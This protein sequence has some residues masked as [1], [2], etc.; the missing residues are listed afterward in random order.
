MSASAPE[1]SPRSSKL[2][3]SAAGWV[4][5]F[6]DFLDY[7][8]PLHF[9]LEQPLRPDDPIAL[10][11]TLPDPP[12]GDQSDEAFF[13]LLRDGSVVGYFNRCAHIQ[14][15]MDFGDGRFLD[16]AGFVLCRL[17]GARYDL[18]SG[19]ACAG[20]ARGH[21]V[22]VRCRLEGGELIVLGWEKLRPAP[23]SGL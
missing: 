14:A 8:P 9:Q 11:L 17:H 18:S 3:R 6:G 16:P 7:D 22:R 20:P 12:N 2:E 5:R 19:E 13:Y 15:P 23:N 10:R 21:L 4:S 1:P